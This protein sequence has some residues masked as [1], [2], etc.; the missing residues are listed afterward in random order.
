MPTTEFMLYLIIVVVIIF[1]LINYYKDNS[2]DQD[3]QYKHIPIHESY[4]SDN[5]ID[6]EPEESAKMRNNEYGCGYRQCAS[7][8]S[9]RDNGQ[10]DYYSHG[11][12][13][14]G[15][16]QHG[17]N[18]HGYNQ[19]GHSQHGY[20]QHGYNQHG[21]NQH[22]YNQHGYDQHGYDQHGY[23]PHGHGLCGN[24]PYNDGP[25][26]YDPYSYMRPSRSVPSPVAPSPVIPIGSGPTPGP[27]PGSVAPGSVAPGSVAPEV[28]PGIPP[29][30]I[31]PLRKFDYD[32]VYDTFTPPFRR[33]YYD[34][35]NYVL[36][37]GLLPTYTRGPIGRF[38]KIGTL[39]AQGVGANDKYKFLNL[40]GRERY[41]NRDFEYYATS[42]NMDQNVKF[43]IETKGKE[44]TDGNIIT[45][46]GLDGY[47]YLFKEDPDLSPRYDPYIV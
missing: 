16:N 23:Y 12:N 43:Y 7:Q 40:I 31:D 32:A 45:V 21:Y 25:H 9:C 34:D 4:I 47:E 15:R 17:Y 10:R 37:H 13:Q 24:S 35:H 20:N 26:G 3:S 18:Q 38:R 19:H 6:M 27:V 22:G 8:G 30:P 39:T 42:T 11:Y 2:N 29:P 36:P 41:P 46:P 14:Y 44:I 28:G 1:L 5:E 33:S